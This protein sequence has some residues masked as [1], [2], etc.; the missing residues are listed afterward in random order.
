MLLN[1]IKRILKLIFRYKY[2]AYCGSNTKIQGLIDKRGKNSL[3]SIGNDC[4]IQGALV[5][6]IDESRISIGNNVFIA[7][8]TLIDCVKSITIEDNVLI[9]YKCTIADSNN[10]SIYYNI[11]HNDLHDWKN[12]GKHDWSTTD[13][14]PIIIRKGCWIGSNVI[15]LKGV[16]I[17]ERAVI[18]AG[19]VVVKDVPSDALVAGNPAKIIKFIDNGDI[20]K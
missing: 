9:S 13:T 20:N 14:R 19:S 1:L 10:H 2:V 17:G 8:G 3:I 6:E 11:R 7:N 12:G 5:T 4:L 15:I 16:V 18:G